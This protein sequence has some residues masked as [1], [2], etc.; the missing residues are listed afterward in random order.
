MNAKTETAVGQSAMRKALWRIVP[1]VAL[2]YLCAYMDRVNVG[3]A[4]VRMNADL[5][6]SATVYGLGAGLF[7][8]GYALLEIPSNLMA[9]RM[10][11]R[12]WLARI[13]I[14][15]GLLS[16]AMLLVRTP[17]QFYAMRFA[18]GVAEA[19]FWPGLIYYFALWFPVSHRGR[20]VS[21]FY[22]ASPVA[23]LVMG[24]VSGALL[25]ME[26]ARLPGLGAL[27]GWQW[28]FL[29]QGLP[30]VAMGLAFLWLLPETPARVAWLTPEE[31]HWIAQELAREAAE[32]GPPASHHLMAALRNPHVLW[33]CATGFFSSGVM[34]TLSLSAPLVLLAATRL[35]T[36]HVGYVVSLG[37]L[38]GAGAMLLAGN[39]SDRRGDRFL[40][41]F[42]W[43]VAMGGSL[44]VLALA[45]RQGM[46][47]GV[48]IG[49]Y[50]GF[51]AT[52]FTVNML[53]SSGWAEVMHP[54]ERA[55]GAAAINMVANLGGFVLPY[56]W[57]ALRDGTGHF[58]AGL[59]GLA[60]ASA[61]A[62]GLT[63]Q[64]RGAPR[65]GR[66]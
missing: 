17:M 60:L 66:F 14:S 30:S 57:G 52:C 5:G 23:S 58:T 50:L 21:R 62:A 35:D 8:L 25:G 39:W 64:V 63:L 56:G 2:G 13:M 61:V 15:W 45:I 51:A 34:T 1:L 31:K 36:T 27:H 55:V 46:A 37:G 41:A 3:F 7:F 43:I 38:A 48:A 9:V 24:A 19:G 22:V 44:L 26:G 42:W 10:G 65:A 59:L 47:P 54:A 53:L 28:L 16:A 6:F 29:A 33:L 4:A 12:R 20:A 11:P 40:N 18:L 32:V 49:G